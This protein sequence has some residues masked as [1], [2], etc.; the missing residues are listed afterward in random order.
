MRLLMP[1]NRPTFS[2]VTHTMTTHQEANPMRLRVILPLLTIL[3]V[4]AC[5]ASPAAPDDDATAEV[6][7]EPTID[8]TPA[9]TEAQAPPRDYTPVDLESV[10]SMTGRLVQVDPASLP[11]F[12]DP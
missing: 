4:A 6:S 2:R 7:A 8:A 10:Y 1:R 5:Q 12:D 3:L 9:P 11:T